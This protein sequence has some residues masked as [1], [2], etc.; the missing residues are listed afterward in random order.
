MGGTLI[1]DIPSELQSKINHDLDESGETRHSVRIEG[2]RLAKFAGQPVAR[3][4]SSHH[5]SILKPGRGLR[6]TARALDGVIEAVEWIGGPQWIV[7]V[8][9][10][11]ERMSGDPLAEALFRSL[12]VESRNKPSVR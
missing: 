7:G 12:I 9:W 2:G 5:Q 6:V 11:P 8:Q 10:H 3:V 1:Q 4:N